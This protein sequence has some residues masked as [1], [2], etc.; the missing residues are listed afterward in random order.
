[1]RY[2]WLIAL[3]AFLGFLAPRTIEAPPTEPDTGVQSATGDF[4]ARDVMTIPQGGS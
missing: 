3:A 1:M 2:F 4:S